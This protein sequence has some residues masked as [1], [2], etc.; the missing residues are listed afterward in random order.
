MTARA[1]RPMSSHHCRAIRPL[2]LLPF[3][4]LTIHDTFGSMNTARGQD[5][6]SAN[7]AKLMQFSISDYTFEITDRFEPGH[8]L[9]AGEAEA[10][11]RL[12][13][14]NIRKNC[15]RLVTAALASTHDGNL[16]P[17]EACLDIQAQ[18]SEYSARYEF[19]ARGETIRPGA[20]QA[21]ALGIAEARL[22]ASKRELYGELEAMDWLDPAEIAAEAKGPVA[23]SEARARVL[24]QRAL[25]R[26]S[27][28]EMLA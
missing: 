11:N 3:Q 2:Q 18:I 13:A 15:S 27:L 6:L 28:E 14:E 1:L 26:A 23:Q 19:E 25:G 17:Y 5:P 24:A 9:S 21:E 7:R 16:L 22:R 12:R 20:I 8:Q 4:P 10:L